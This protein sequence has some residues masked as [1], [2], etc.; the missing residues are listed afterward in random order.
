MLAGQWAPAAYKLL[1]PGNAS[2]ICAGIL[3]LP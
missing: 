2:L 1:Q 3:L